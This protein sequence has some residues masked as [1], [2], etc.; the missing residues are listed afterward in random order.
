MLA[1][2]YCFAQVKIPGQVY[3]SPDGYV[4]Y[5]A[6]NLPLI[7]SV[8][9]GGSLEPASIPDRACADC[10]TVKDAFTSELAN[11]FL[12]E[13]FN[14]TG[15]YP[16]VIF[17]QLHRKKMDANRGIAE[18][19]D[20]NAEAEQAW[21]T[22]HQ[23]LEE[24]GDTIVYHYGKGLLIDLHGHAHTIQRLE[25]GYLLT[26][27]ELR[28]PDDSLNL[29]RLINESSI[30]NLAL[31]HT[32]EK[33]HAELLR[34]EAALGSL[35]GTNNY[36][37][38]PSMAD[39]APQSGQSYFSGGYITDRH[40]SK[41]G[42][43]IDAIQ[44][45]CN[46]DV[47]FTSVERKKFARALYDQLFA[48]VSEHYLDPACLVSDIAE[49][50]RHTPVTLLPNP[51]NTRLTLNHVAKGSLLYVYDATGKKINE[52]VSITFESDKVEIDISVLSPGL[53]HLLCRTENE[54]KP[55]A[56]KFM[57]LR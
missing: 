53:Y 54:I 49:P 37:A 1:Q 29:P 6:G 8:P 33:T 50:L 26:A 22:Y 12:T 36:P 40:G 34:G 52:A 15:C 43:T 27:G 35:L 19:A 17:N 42:G 21:L 25:L 14:Q 30:K 13:V 28:L 31:T 18:A 38:V 41:N 32:G 24:A 5:V 56:L 44:M 46:Q 23:F 11:E 51:A 3:T 7:M 20:G 39:R 10:V 2:L 9:H 45:E 48:F 4:T 55:I 57:V 16:H 47:R